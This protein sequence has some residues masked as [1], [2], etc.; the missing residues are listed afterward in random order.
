MKDNMIDGRIRVK[1]NIIWYDIWRGHEFN[2][3]HSINVH[4][5]YLQDFLNDLKVANIT[6]D[7]LKQYVLIVHTNWEGHNAQD[8]EPFRT[9]LWNINFPMTQFGTLF[10]CFE[11]TNNLPYPAECVPERLIYIANWHPDLKKQQIQW[12]DL[13]MQTKCVILMR[14]ASESRCLL[15]RKLLDSFIPED[16]TITLGTF[17]DSVP[18]H[19]RDIVKP[20]QY[21]LVVDEDNIED[22]KHNP[23]HQLFYT[24]PVQLVVESSHETDISAWRN[25]F[26]TEKSYK[27][28]AWHQ[29]ALWYAVPGTVG[30]LRDAGFDLFEDIIDHSY[31]NESD[32][33]KRMDM[34]VSQL[35]KFCKHDTAKLL[36]IYH[37]DRLEYN[38]QLVE[39]ITKTAY[40]IHKTKA[41]QLQDELLQLYKSGKSLPTQ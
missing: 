28:F 20:Y 5:N 33:L 12:A 34:V 32:P 27:A 40:I 11:D 26:I 9:M 30:K 39:K 23:D 4:E 24:S 25:I 18:Q 15:A 16:I 31:D 14:R 13:E 38:A 36:R 41:E 1:N 6:I 3:L 10:T 8:I 22:T 37:W 19:W 35:K 17:P 21:P 2:R 29:F 7:E